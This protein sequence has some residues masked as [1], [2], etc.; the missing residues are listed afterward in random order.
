MSV[1]P[2]WNFLRTDSAPLRLAI[3]RLHLPLQD[4]PAPPIQILLLLFG[5]R[6]S[7][8]VAAVPLDF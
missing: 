3:P 2:H 7:D 4:M 5:E 1:H 6:R 8:V